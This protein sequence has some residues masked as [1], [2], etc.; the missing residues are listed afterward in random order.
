MMLGDKVFYKIYFQKHLN[1]NFGMVAQKFM[2]ME[3]L[4]LK[5]FLMNLFLNQI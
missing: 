4:N 1:F 2:E 3:F 5:L